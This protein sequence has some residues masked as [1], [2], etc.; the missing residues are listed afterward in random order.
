MSIGK[1]CNREVVFALKANTA[2]EAAQLMRRHH[3]GDVVIVESRDGHRV[4]LGIVTDR[5]IVIEVMAMGLDPDAVT[6][7]DIMSQEIVTARESDGIFETIQLMRRKGV[8]RIPIVSHG[9]GLI[10]IV[11]ID[12]LLELLA[13]ELTGL[14]HVMPRERAA[15]AKARP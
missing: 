2:R 3:V 6:G 13:E 15:E 1:V 4:P 11:S 5:D 14:S 7:G 12:D 8:R 10:G 9:G